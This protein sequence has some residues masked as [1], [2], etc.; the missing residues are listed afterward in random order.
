MKYSGLK[1]FNKDFAV[2]SLQTQPVRTLFLSPAIFMEGLT[3]T[4][5]RHVYKC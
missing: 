4:L 3:L 2:Y 1:P 5:L